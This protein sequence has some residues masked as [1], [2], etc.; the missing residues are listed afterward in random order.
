MKAPLL[1]EFFIW[2]MSD[3]FEMAVFRIATQAVT[4]NIYIRPVMDMG[5]SSDIRAALVCYPLTIA[6]NVIRQK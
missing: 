4:F 3:L 2:H 5:T 1:E 6:K